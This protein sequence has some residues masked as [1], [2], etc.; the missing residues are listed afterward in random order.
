MVWK[1]TWYC[2]LLYY[3]LVVITLPTQHWTKFPLHLVMMYKSGIFQI[4]GTFYLLVESW[5]H[6]ITTALKTIYFL[7]LYFFEKRQF[8]LQIYKSAPVRQ[9]YENMCYPYCTHIFKLYNFSLHNVV[10]ISLKLCKNIINCREY[11]QVECIYIVYN[12]IS[13][14]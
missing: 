9:Y 14:N 2:Y 4:D 5:C 12:V 1:C 11:I 8:A 3:V 10:L 6:K 7:F 13:Q